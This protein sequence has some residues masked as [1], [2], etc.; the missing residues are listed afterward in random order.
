MFEAKGI[1][2]EEI[3]LCNNQDGRDHMR[4]KAGIEN[5]LP[6]AIFND[7]TYCGVKVFVFSHVNICISD[8]L[9]L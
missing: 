3:D 4:E 8:I 7:D 1:T 9:Y 2:F 5:L 6:P